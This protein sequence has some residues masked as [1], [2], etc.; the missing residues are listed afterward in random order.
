MR[1]SGNKWRTDRCGRCGE[2]H[3]HYTGKLDDDDVEYVVCGF[4]NAR[5]DVEGLGYYGTSTKWIRER[6]LWGQWFRVLT[7]RFFNWLGFKLTS[8]ERSEIA[9]WITR[10][11]KE[12]SSETLAKLN[13][14]VDEF[15]G[16]IVYAPYI[17]I[18][19][20]KVTQNK[21]LCDEFGDW[22][23]R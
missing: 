21:E 8:D 18:S 12:S 4:V 23:I 17:S 1:K 16:R 3:T 22:L 6:G 5:M 19:K 15:G 2:K 20:I 11:I 7:L 14:E 10:N 13:G 9:F